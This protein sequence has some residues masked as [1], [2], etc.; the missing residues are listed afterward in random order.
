MNAIL[1][2]ASCFH[3]GL[4]VPA[5]ARWHVTIDQTERAMCCPGCEAVAQTIIDIG[6]GSYYRERDAYAV[7]AADTAILP[8]ELRLYSNDDVQFA[9]D[10]DSCEATLSV[11]GIRCAA[12]VWLIERQ[13]LRLPG[14]QAAS[15]NVATE[16][17][18]V[19]WSKQQCAPGD[20]LQ[21]V[22]QVGY[23]AYPYDAVRHGEQLQQASKTLGRQLFVAGLSMMQVMMY[24]APAY[25]AEDGTLDDNMASLMRWASLLLTL[26]AICYSAMPFFQGAWSSLRARTL[27]MDVP[28]TLGILAAFFGSVVATFTGRGEVY[29]D[30]ATMFIFLLLC[31]R[32]FELQARR[33]AASAL[34]RLQ[35][36]LPASASLLASF[37]DSRA[38]TLVPAGSLAVGDIILVK[39]GEAIAADSVIVEG[40]SALDLS[41]LTGESAAQR[42]KAG[43]RVPGGAINASAALILRVLKPARDSTLSDLLKLIERAGSGK[44]QIALWADKVA[45]WFVL[46]LL[47][48]AAAVF[49]FWSWHDAAQAWPVAIAVL[50]VSCPCALSLATPTALAAATDSLLRRGV[51]IVQPHVLETL[52][53]ATHIVFDKTG[54]L[55]VGKPVLQ[56]IEALGYL[57][58]DDCLQVAAVLEAGSAHPLAQAILDAA[59]EPLCHAEQ[60]QEVQGQGL[61]GLVDGVRYRLGNAAFVASIAGPP[62]GDTAVGVQGMTPLYLGVQDQWLARFLLSDALRPEAQEVIDYFH[63]RGKQVVLLSGDQ[64]ALTQGVATQL[65]IATAC[66]ECLPDE[67]LDFVQQLQAQGAVVAMVGDGINDAAVL[68]AADVSFAMGSGAA[69]AQAHADTVL[70]SS[71]L[72]SVQDTA[73]T[74][75]RSMAI[76]RENLAW[77]T[78]YNLTAIPAAALGFLN[79]WLSG[80]GMAASSAVVIANALRLRKV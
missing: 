39:P 72:R 58:Q 37:P 38:A 28:V 61:E 68:S 80:V 14:V 65:G 69:L 51:L 59:G 18:Y 76:I 64:E 49:A 5:G 67:K 54:T 55:T 79:P 74:A 34:E 12:C 66:G 31:S 23:T 25:L 27:G 44:P 2:S 43:E 19:R 62:L 73:K 15:L 20:I 11:V 53:R 77:A 16:R 9:R 21:A 24:V 8:P 33:K 47:L 75:A 60:L 52:H 50:V 70:L 57:A 35:H 78:L 63:R 1:Q 42:R 46:G 26:P 40:N 6:Q 7:N 36:A 56:Q 22:R 41:L 30:S 3:C 4:P 32:Y 17:M 45:A 48:F 29:F 71:Q 13:L 10:A